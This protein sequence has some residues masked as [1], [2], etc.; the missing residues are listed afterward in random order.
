ME[1]GKEGTREISRKEKEKEYEEKIEEVLIK[2][3][4]EQ[5]KEQYAVLLREVTER[6]ITLDILNY[7][8]KL[9][10]EETVDAQ[11]ISRDLGYKKE[12]VEEVLSEILRRRALV[13]SFV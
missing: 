9:G 3:K 10:D 1:M 4:L 2:R 5:E 7:I 6:E 11:K 8:S 13:S 12:K